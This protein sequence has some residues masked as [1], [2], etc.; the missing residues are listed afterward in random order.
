MRRLIEI[1]VIPHSEQRYDSWADW[2]V[3][4]DGQ[5]AITTSE[6]PKPDW[7]YDYLSVIHELLEATL[8]RHQ[9]ITQ[10]DVDAF[11]IDY[12]SR[13]MAGQTHAACGCEITD[14]PG[15]DKHAPY[16]EA[17]LY[18]CSVEYGLA[19]LLDVDPAAYDAAF[20]ALDGGV[21]GNRK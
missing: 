12:E 17:H 8:C 6:L 18:A 15:S 14:D 13:R 16:R 7:R 10:A 3:A 4:A 19:R 5:L 9:G 20:I 1:N 21:A 11:D 2:Q